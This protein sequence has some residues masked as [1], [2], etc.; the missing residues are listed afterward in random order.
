MEQF[1]SR[2]FAETIEECDEEEEEEE[3]EKEGENIAAA[4]LLNARL[5]TDGV[6]VSYQEPLPPQI[7]EEEEEEEG[8]ESYQEFL[9]KVKNSCSMLT[10]SLMRSDTSSATLPVTW[11]SSSLD[12]SPESSQDSLGKLAST[13]TGSSSSPGPAS[14]A[15]V[16]GPVILL[17]DN[18]DPQV[19]TEDYQV[20]PPVYSSSSTSASLS[21]SESGSM[22]YASFIPDRCLVEDE[23][24]IVCNGFTQ[25]ETDSH[26]TTASESEEQQEQQEE[27]VMAE[28]VGKEKAWTSSVK[29]PTLLDFWERRN[30]E[31]QFKK[32]A[33]E[34]NICK[35]QELPEN[36]LRKIPKEKYFTSCEESFNEESDY[37]VRSGY[38]DHIYQRIET[39]TTATKR[40][41]DT[42]PQEESGFFSYEN[43][44]TSKS[45]E[46]IK[47][48]SN[49][50]YYED[51]LSDPTYACIN[52]SRASIRDRDRDSESC[53]DNNVT[54]IAVDFHQTNL[55]NNNK[56]PVER[57]HDRPAKLTTSVKDLRKL[58]EN[59]QQGP[60]TNNNKTVKKITKR[61]IALKVNFLSSLLSFNFQIIYFL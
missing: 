51:D 17:G 31:S 25:I 42:L 53:S 40:T 12:L 14:P 39:D 10:G 19:M 55:N 3:E 9:T 4:P 47:H 46:K 58:F 35:N 5:K 13:A 16:Q 20:C 24:S 11:S 30:K 23:V 45:P 60:V 34:S 57:E 43:T 8:D 22:F 27:P 1:R 37:S 56:P 49:G 18:F 59:N 54:V 38:E 36:G 2:N 61:A 33:S 50:S 32:Y 44:N 28:M 15:T 41:G 21:T 29:L 48:R 7:S 26:H 6:C 52:W